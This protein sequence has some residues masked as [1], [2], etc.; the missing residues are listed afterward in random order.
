MPAQDDGPKSTGSIQK[1]CMTQPP[2][3]VE[4]VVDVSGRVFQRAA[5]IFCHSLEID[6]IVFLDAAVGTHGGLGRDTD[7]TGT[8]TGDS[9]DSMAALSHPGSGNDEPQPNMRRTCKVLGCAQTVRKAA[10]GTRSPAKKLTETFLRNFMHRNPHGKIW[11][12]DETGK[13]H[14]EDAFSSDN[15]SPAAEVVPNSPSTQQR[16]ASRRERRSDGENLQLIFPGARCVALHGIYD[17]TRHRWSV[18]GLYWTYDPL[19]ML[20]VESE[21]H[22]VAAF[23]DVIV[24]E[25]SRLEVLG[26]DK[27][28]SDF[29]SS[30]SHELRS[31]LHG[32]LGSTEILAEQHCGNTTM[33]L[34][35]QIDSCGH[36]LLEVI[37]HLL[38]FADLKHQRLKKGSV[39]SSKIGRK[40]LPTPEGASADNDLAALK[41]H[42]ALDRLTEEA[43]VSSVYSYYYNEGAERRTQISVILDIDRNVEQGWRCQ[44]AT[45]GWIPELCNAFG[46]TYDHRDVGM[47]IERLHKK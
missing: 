15:E 41:L 12:F 8:S 19:R 4:D 31:P 32:I 22:F 35:E 23:C 5:E 44:L 14:S 42:V 37:D 16:K 30:S 33:T 11:S 10:G 46:Y 28:K 9:E 2:N 39:K 6:G 29:I 25:T 38:D 45:G 3:E 20:P 43:I 26:S 18:G 27:V 17:Y 7:S 34:I 40:F 36:T 13:E 1:A 21:M 24:A 47:I